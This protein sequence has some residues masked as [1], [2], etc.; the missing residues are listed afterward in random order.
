VNE[1]DLFALP[2]PD[3]WALAYEDEDPLAL[4]V[5]ERRVALMRAHDPAMPDHDRCYKR[6]HK[7]GLN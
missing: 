2:F 5:L 4:A 1:P 7:E 6:A 3:L